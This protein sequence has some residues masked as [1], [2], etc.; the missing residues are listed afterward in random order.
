V[1]I[2]AIRLARLGDVV[3]LLP[4]L[5]GL[6][7][8]FPEAHLTVLTGSRCEPLIRMCP[9]VDEVIGVDRLAM[10]DG[11]AIA[12][13]GEIAGLVRRIRKRR[14]DVAIDF[15]GLRETTALTG[16]S[17]ATR[18]MGLRRFWLSLFFSLPV[19]P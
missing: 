15:H 1:K 8:R 10:R 3:L 7:S 6:K 14:F 17:R 4:S 12:A 5:A 13:I 11:S 9:A 18:R 16:L 2:L 19:R